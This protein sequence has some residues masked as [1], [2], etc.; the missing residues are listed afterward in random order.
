MCQ[1]PTDTLTRMKQYF[2]YYSIPIGI[3]LL[4]SIVLFLPFFRAGFIATDDGSWMIIRLSAFYQ[5][6]REGQFPVRFLGRLNYEYGYPVA[7]FLYPGFLYIGSV[8][9]FLGMSFIAAIKSIIGFS[10]FGAS[11]FLYLWLRKFFRRTPATVAAVGFIF[12]P[13]VGYDIY[14]R[15][16]V[17]EILAFLWV[18]MALWAI[19]T[20]RK[21]WATIAFAMLVLSHNSLALLF[22]VFIF[23]YLVATGRLKAYSIPG[24]LAVGM[25]M[26]FWAPALYE[27]KYVQF[28]STTISDPRNYFVTFSTAWLMGFPALL[29]ALL[30]WTEKPFIKGKTFYILWYG[31]ALMCAM[32]ISVLL[33]RQEILASVF[34]F[35]FRFLAVTQIVGAWCIAAVLEMRHKKMLGLLVI[36]CLGFGMQFLFVRA[37]V[38]LEHHPEEYYTTNEATTTIADEYFPRWVSQ[39]PTKRPEQQV[40]FYQG[41]G[42]IT[43]HAMTL[44]SVDFTV[45][46]S[47]ESIIQINTMYYPG[48]GVT[49]NNVLAPVDYRNPMGVMRV[50][51]PQ[52]THRVVTGFRETVSRFV[53]DVVSVVCG[54]LFIVYAWNE[55]YTKKKIS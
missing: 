55:A 52:G 7:N 48:M 24:M 43:P 25:S 44:S 12:G 38:R 8:L 16:S 31:F 54:L 27:Q 32:P 5:S 6:L 17:G 22:G 29:A 33:W 34:Q 53:F 23:S 42:T 26:F 51:I 46:V 49:L 41:A 28:A 11:V 50:T 39:K 10:V 45:D 13:Y 47:E 9:H 30:V 36:L 21:S 19:E 15:G 14:Q 18:A 3:L 4:C 1:I 20:G 35:P 2:S 40:E 37:L